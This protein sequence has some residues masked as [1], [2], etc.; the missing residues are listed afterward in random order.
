MAN[1]KVAIGEDWFALPLQTELLSK[2]PLLR[3]A[4]VV[5]TAE[6][7]RFACQNCSL[8]LTPKWR[9]G[10]AWTI[11]DPALEAETEVFVA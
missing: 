1:R 2:L 7:I 5:Q 8:A 9:G 10:P 6:T 3:A 11:T 4:A